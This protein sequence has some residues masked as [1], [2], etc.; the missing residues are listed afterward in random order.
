MSM[1]WEG[2]GGSSHNDYY[3]VNYDRER[4]KNNIL[5]KENEELKKEIESVNKKLDNSIELSDEV[6]F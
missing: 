2:G 3:E 1:M 6:I 5:S 4:K